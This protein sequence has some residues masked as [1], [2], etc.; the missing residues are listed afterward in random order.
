MEGC[1]HQVDN[2]GDGTY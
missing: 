2:V 1:I